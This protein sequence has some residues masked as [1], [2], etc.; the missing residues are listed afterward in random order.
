M[1][2]QTKA[3]G[4]GG[5]TD[6]QTRWG[7]VA[8]LMDAKGRDD[9]TDGYKGKIGSDRRKV[10]GGGGWNGQAIG[11]SGEGMARKTEGGGWPG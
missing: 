4:E 6:R 2:R 5:W 7:E 1:A 8:T 9:Q 3:G 10:G 11:R